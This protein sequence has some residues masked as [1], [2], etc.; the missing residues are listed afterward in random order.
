MAGLY[1]PKVVYLCNVI[2]QQHQSS[3]SPPVYLQ[4]HSIAARAKPCVW[5][6]G[7]GGR[8][9]PILPAQQQSQISLKVVCNGLIRITLRV[10]CCHSYIQPRLILIFLVRSDLLVLPHV[11]RSAHVSQQ[12]RR[13]AHGWPAAMQS[14]SSLANHLQFA[15]DI[16]QRPV[17]A[18]RYGGLVAS[19]LAKGFFMTATCDG[20]SA[21]S[22][23]GYDI[24]LTGAEAC[25]SIDQRPHLGLSYE[26]NRI[27]RGQRK[28]SP[29]AI[30][31][32]CQQRLLS[33]MYNG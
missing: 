28:P 11:L 33:Y 26:L 14:L 30:P 25:L 17:A 7:V 21:P 1:R 19:R 29:S 10:P 2:L 16:V 13:T 15:L 6:R 18:A 3:L 8:A 20:L 32:T 5:S 27:S 4:P 31:K 23:L 12:I 24:G 22:W 9:A